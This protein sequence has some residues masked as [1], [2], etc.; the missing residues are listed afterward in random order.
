MGFLPDQVILRSKNQLPAGSHQVDTGK[1]STPG[2]GREMVKVHRKNGV[3]PGP[4]GV[5]KNVEN[6]ESVD[7]PEYSP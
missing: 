5:Q 6:V 7:N 1:Y 4:R 2:L 3:D